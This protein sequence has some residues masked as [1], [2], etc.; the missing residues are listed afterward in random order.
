M[1]RNSVLMLDRSILSN[2]NNSDSVA[3]RS[4]SPTDNTHTSKRTVVTEEWVYLSIVLLHDI[5]V[6]V[7]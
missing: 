1:S 6:S 5:I 7:Q 3:H 2:S 4:H